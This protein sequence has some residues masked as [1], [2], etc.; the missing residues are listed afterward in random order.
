MSCLGQKTKRG[1]LQGVVVGV[2]APNAGTSILDA[3][4]PGQGPDPVDLCRMF[5]LTSLPFQIH[6][7]PSSEGHCGQKKPLKNKNTE[8]KDKFNAFQIHFIKL[9]F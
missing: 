7:L 1:S 3:A 5:S 4:V 2:R 6:R 8:E 9:M